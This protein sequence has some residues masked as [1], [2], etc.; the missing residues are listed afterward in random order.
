[1]TTFFIPQPLKRLVVGKS[2]ASVGGH[3]KDTKSG[4][5]GSSGI[6]ESTTIITGM[7]LFD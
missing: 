7:K 3:E 5:S 2:V 1:L 4:I 6:G